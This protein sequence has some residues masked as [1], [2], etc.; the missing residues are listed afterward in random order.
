MHPPVN[1]ESERGLKPELLMFL[2]DK[3]L[4]LFNAR[5]DIEWKVFLSVVAALGLMDATILHSQRD[6]S[7]NYFVW[8][9]WTTICLAIVGLPAL[10]LRD[11]QSR[12]AR[13]RRAM[14]VLHNQ[15]CGLLESTSKADLKAIREP[16]EPNPGRV[17]L[18]LQLPFLVIAGVLSAAL[19][20][21]VR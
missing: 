18:G 21:L 13:D 8:A 6:I 14:N 10:L 17:V 2:Y 7:G 11:L 20:G 19:P 15:L 3:R 1:G 5:R 9:V 4:T 12:N 16:R